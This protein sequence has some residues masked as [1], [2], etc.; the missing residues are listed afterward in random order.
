[1]MKKLSIL[2]VLSL[3]ALRASGY[4][5]CID[6]IYY[7]FSD[8]EAIV[9]YQSPER[10]YNTNAYS[11]DVVIPETVTYN[12][13]V[14]TVTSINNNAF[15]YCVNLT[16]VSI[17]ST[18]TSIGDYVFCGCRNLSSIDIPSSVVSVGSRIMGETE[19][20][21]NQPDGLVY[22]GHIVYGYKGTMPDNTSLEFRDGTT[23]IAANAFDWSETLT[24]ITIPASV[25]NIGRSAFNMCKNLNSV[26]ISDLAAWVSI[27]FGSNPLSFAKH[28]YLNGE[29]VT[30]WVIPET[31]TSIAPYAFY[32]FSGLESL[33]IPN[34][35]TDIGTYA[36]TGCKG[37]KYLSINCEKIDDWF[38]EL[39]IETL[40]IG[41]DVTEIGKYAFWNC[42]SLSQLSIGK[43][44]T[45]I[46]MY[47]FDGCG[48]KQLIIPNNVLTLGKST[49]GNCENLER[50][51]VGNGVTKLPDYV[52]SNTRIKSLTIGTGVKEVSP[53]TVGIYSNIL[54]SDSYQYP[55]KVIWMGNDLPSGYGSLEG[56]GGTINYSASKGWSIYAH[57]KTYVIGF[58]YELLSSK[59]EVDGITYVPT[60]MSERTCDVIDCNYDSTNETIK[61]G[62]TV[63]YKGITF[64]VNNIQRYAF[65]MNEYIK[66]VE[67][68]NDGLINYNAFYQCENLEKAKIWNNGIIGDYAFRYCGV[69]QTADLGEGVTSLGGYA[70][71]DCSALQKI[72]IPDAV[73]TI[74]KYAFYNCTSMESASIGAGL[75][76]IED[77]SFLNCTS[78]KDFQMGNNITNIGNS[79]FSNCESLLRLVIPKSV[80]RIDDKFTNCSSLAELIIEDSDET[81]T[82]NFSAMSKCGLDT[83]YVGR[84]LSASPFMNNTTL[85]AVKITDKETEIARQAFYGCSNLKNLY[86]GNNIKKI[87]EKAF[88]GCAS[89]ESFVVGPKVN[90]I[91]YA[92]FSDCINIK[93]II[94]HAVTP[95]LCYSQALSDIDKWTCTLTVP[96]GSLGAYS[97]ADQWKEFFLVEESNERII[98]SGDANGNGE[99]DPED[100]IETSNAILGNP[101]E[102]FV[103]EA[104]DMNG[105]KKIDAADI[106]LMINEIKAN[107]AQ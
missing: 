41:D 83:V 37:L 54:K 106:V 48:M 100:V 9:T 65:Y 49:F 30:E 45:T 75:T 1:M 91:E 58:K 26:Y 33:T 35:L 89:L 40:I 80:V 55:Y 14:Y 8:G 102:Q 99:L 24:E 63:T 12:S 62:P 13:V 66:E 73:T 77:G 17:P 82:I 29:E 53:H 98:V 10:Q 60:S 11:G 46:D 4:T 96:K 74:G 59:F 7:D 101:S 72:V 84:R 85:R 104:A 94:S 16:S 97:E 76:K 105:D 42:G 18:V 71:S 5:A 51:I 6:G 44:V 61:I 21:N 86:L 81:L 32:Q 107:K 93:S 28:L 90:I 47:A 34:T 56:E 52:F 103:E 23:C 57:N 22:I 39:N 70:F 64:K 50:V 38:R 92:A 27:S 88:F 43:S 95:P 68:E 79:A 3:W 36:F 19:W 2:C 31:I 25:K 20:Y 69:M 15:Y 87:G 78:L 67:L